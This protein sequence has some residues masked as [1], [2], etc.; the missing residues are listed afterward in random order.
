M[1]KV[2]PLIFT[3]AV[4][5]LVGAIFGVVLFS[6]VWNNPR[7]FYQLLEYMSRINETI[8]FPILIMVGLIF[9]SMGLF[10][11][12]H[13]FMTILG[14]INLILAVFYVIIWTE[15][16]Y[17]TTVFQIYSAF[18]FVLDILL[19]IRAILIRKSSKLPL[20]FFIITAILG[21]FVN[22]LFGI[23]G[24]SRISNPINYIRINSS[25]Q[26][27]LEI[28]LLLLTLY[29]FIRAGSYL[30]MSFAE[31]KPQ[32]KGKLQTT[33]KQ[34]KDMG[35]ADDFIAFEEEIAPKP[36]K[37]KTKDNYEGFFC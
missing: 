8:A 20:I 36:I 1:A 29:L 14:I 7:T 5:Q 16:I 4:V 10:L 3:G 37:S 17:F 31:I 6:Q 30:V 23:I 2:S 13:S 21:I 24:F 19:V 11:S 25:I 28:Y 34:S 18:L 35:N 27:Y 15:M 32:I 26:P 22:L 33:S 9:C 12:K